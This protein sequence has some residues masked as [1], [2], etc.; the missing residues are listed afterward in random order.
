M[1]VI[2]ESELRQGSKKK[3]NNMKFEQIIDKKKI[4]NK[5]FYK[6]WW[7]GYLKAEAT[8]VSRANSVRKCTENY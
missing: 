8:W 4:G 5:I 7:K 2:T 1:L 6:V 3:K